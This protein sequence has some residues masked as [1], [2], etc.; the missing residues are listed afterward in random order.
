MR[1]LEFILWKER[2]RAMKNYEIEGQISFFGNEPYRPNKDTSEVGKEVELNTEAEEFFAVGKKRDVVREKTTS[3]N[4]VAHD[5]TVNHTNRD[6]EVASDENSRID[7]VPSKESKRDSQKIQKENPSAEFAK[8]L[9]KDAENVAENEIKAEIE[10]SAEKDAKK[11]T[12][13]NIKKD[14]GKDTE[15]VNLDNAVMKKI[16]RLAGKELTVAYLDYNKVY[17]KD[18]TGETFLVQYSDAKAAVDAYISTLEHFRALPG[19]KELDA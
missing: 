1:I 3:Q 14:I 19:A 6:D 10:K 9:E 11:D 5:K 2:K 8:K 15:N 12:R 4:V 16:F 17:S 7:K 18:E 13:K